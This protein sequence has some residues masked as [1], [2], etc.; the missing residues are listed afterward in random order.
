MKLPWHISDVAPYVVD[1]AWTAV[2]VDTSAVSRVSDAGTPSD[3]QA[4][5]FV[6]CNTCLLSVYCPAV[7]GLHVETAG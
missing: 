1:V 6:A 7:A 3:A 4:I 2:A 5:H